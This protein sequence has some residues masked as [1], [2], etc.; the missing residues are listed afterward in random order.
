M[1]RINKQQ[2]LSLLSFKVVFKGLKIWR[3]F[4]RNIIIASAILISSLLL[5]SPS[6][7]DDDNGK[8]DHGGKLFS[9]SA[10]V[11]IGQVS[12]LL[13]EVPR[14]KNLLVTQY[15]RDFFF[16]DLVGSELGRVPSEQNSSCTT[17][18]PGVLF[19]GGQSISCITRFADAGIEMACLVNGVIR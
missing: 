18:E 15:C 5:V 3:K 6:L 13:A 8:F 17:Y 10:T 16:L 19:K 12:V 2:N 4:M 7:G 9:A 1:L 11:P 14:G